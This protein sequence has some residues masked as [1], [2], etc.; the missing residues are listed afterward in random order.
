[1]AELL[2]DA[3]IFGTGEPQSGLLSDADI[4]GVGAEPTSTPP[5]SGIGR[6]E[7]AGSQFV[8][9]AADV[10]ASVPKS[11]S[12]IESARAEAV[13]DA[14]DKIDAGAFSGPDDPRLWADRAYANPDYQGDLKSYFSASDEGKQQLR[15][16]YGAIFDNPQEQPLYKK[17]EEISERTAERFPVNPE[18]ASEFWAGTVPQGLGS[19]TGFLATGAAGR[20]AGVSA[21]ATAAGAGA[22]VG[23][24]GQFEEA[25][26]DGA[27]LEEAF[28]AGKLSAFVG[29]S[30][31]VPITGL[32]NRLDK[33]TGGGVKKALADAAKQ[34]TE[35]AVQEAF[36]TI[37]SNLIASDLVGYDPERNAF[38]G[39]GE[40][41]GAGF[42][43]GA[44]MQG[45]AAMVMPGRYRKA[46]DEGAQEQPA[47]DKP[48]APLTDADRASPLP[49]DLISEGKGLMDELLS[50]QD[51]GI[52]EGA[53]N[54]D[55]ILGTEQPQPA[56]AQPEAMTGEDQAPAQRVRQTETE[57]GLLSDE[58]V[59]GEAETAQKGMTVRFPAVEGDGSPQ[60]PVQV[61]NGNDADVA[62][63]RVAEPTEAQKEAGNYRKGH[64]KVSG[65][66]VSIENPKGSTRS[67]T[68]ADGN[69]WSVE[70]PAHYG[71]VK[72]TEGADGDHVDVYIGD[73]PESDTVYVVDQINADEGTF[74]EHKGLV[75]FQSAEAAIAA[76]DAAFNDGRGPDRRGAVTPMSVEAFRDWLKGG[77]TKKPI[78]WKRQA[79][80]A[81][82]PESTPSTFEESE[83]PASEGS[84]ITP[85][86]EPQRYVAALKRYATTTKKPLNRERIAKDL[87]IEPGQADRV[88]ASLV[89]QADAPITVS[90]DGTV[91]RRAQRKGPVDAITYLADR[92]G[93]N[94][95]EGHDLKKGRNLQRFV[96]QA[97]P[98]IR[99][100][101]MSIDEAGETLW[102]AGYFGPTDTTQR[103]TEAEVLD[104]IEQAH[105]GRGFTPEDQDQVDAAQRAR[106][107]EERTGNAENEIRDIAKDMGEIFG[108][109][110]VS[111][112]KEMAISQNMDAEAAVEVY[113]ERQAI[114]DAEE[115]GEAVPNEDDA[116]DIPFE[117][118]TPESGGQAG[119]RRVERETQPGTS[120]ESGD[121]G[122]QVAETGSQE[123]SQERVTTETV[124][125]VDGPREQSVIPGAEQSAHQAAQSRE[126]EGRGRI[127]PKV[128]QKDADEGLFAPE[129]TQGE[130]FA[131]R[132][133]HAIAFTR[134]LDRL[135]AGEMERG[136]V[137]SLGPTPPALQLAGLPGLPLV[138][139]Q[140]EARKTLDG[141]HKGLIDEGT[142]RR[143][144][145]LL[146]DPVLVSKQENNRY[147]A[148]IQDA[149]GG[150]VLVVIQPRGVIKNRPSNLV[151]TTH[152][153][154]RADSILEDIAN[155]RVTYRHKERSLRWFDQAQRQNAGEGAHRG[156]D[157]NIATDADLVNDER[158]R[159]RESTPSE[160]I[161][162]TI[163]DDLKARMKQRGIDDKVSLRIVDSLATVLPDGTQRT[164]DASYQPGR[165]LIT[166]ALDAK[167]GK[168]A[169]DHEAVH[170]LR[171]LG[172]F[173]DAEWRVLENAARND[174]KRM[175][176]IRK[177]YEPAGLTESQLEEEAIA[178]M[179]AD[180]AKGEKKTK[181][182]IRTAFERIKAFLESLGNALEGNGYRTA[183]D[184]FGDVE[185]GNIGTRPA[186]GQSGNMDTKYAAAWHGT[187][188]DFDVFKTDHIGTGEGA[189]AYGWG[190]YFAGK[191]E[192]AEHYQ[193]SLTQDAELDSFIES[194]A[195]RV[196]S[197]PDHGGAIGVAK[198]KD[199]SVLV[200]DDVGEGEAYGPGYTDEN[201]PGGPSASNTHESRRALNEYEKLKNQRGRLYKVDL[202]PQEDEYLLWDKPLKDQPQSEILL[203]LADEYGVASTA[204]GG[205][206]Y[207]SVQRKEG[208]GRAASMAIARSGI[209]GIKYLDGSSRNDGEGTY[210][211]VIFDDS[212]VSVTEKYSL[213]PEAADSQ[214]NRNTV[215]Q[216]FIARGQPLDRALRIPFD[217]FGGVDEKGEWQPGLKLYEKAEKTLTESR[218]RDDGVFGWLNGSLTAARTGL[219]DRYGLNEDYVRRERKL[220]LDKREIASKGAEILSFLQSENIGA[221][222]AKVL[223]AVLTG[224]EIGDAEWQN[225]AA[226]IRQAIDELGQEAVQLGLVSPESYERNHGTYLHRVYLKHEGDQPALAR[227]FTNFM[228]NKRKK[229]QGDAFKGRGIFLDVGIDRAMQDVTEFAEG[230]RGRPQKGE[231]FIILDKFAEEGG[232]VPAEND[233]A[234]PAKIEK[235][236]FWPADKAVPERYAKEGYQNR[237]EWEVRRTLGDKI[238]LWRDFTKAERAQMGEILDARYT[239]GKTFTLM[240]NDLATGR[241]YRDIAQN[242]E[243]A[244]TATPNG[245]WV[246]AGDFKRMW[247][248]ESVEWVRVPDVSIPNTGNKK[249][250]GAL[251]GK[252]VRAEI[253]RDLNEADIMMRPNLWTKLLTQW[254]LNKTARSPVVHMNNVMSN[255]VF[256]DLAD[257]RV[258][259]L[260]KGLRSYI[261]EDAEFQDA[262]DHGAFGSDIIS[263]EIRRNVLQPIL[264]DLQSEVAGGNPVTQKFGMLGK[265]A[266]AIWEKGKAF[267]RGMVE[268]YRM[269][270][271]VFRMAM[272]HRRRALGDSTENAADEARAQFL[273]YDI[274]APW[275]NTARR[276]ALPFIAYTY[277]AV[278]V[279]AKSVATRPWKMA[280]YFAMAY[281]ANALAYMIAPGD[282]DDE[283]NSMREQEKGN[284]WIGTPRMMRMPYRDEHGNPVFLDIRRWI[285]AGDVFDMGQGHGAFP[286]PAPIQFGGPLMLGAEL[287]LNK[288]AFTGDEI[289]NNLTDSAS[290]KAKKLSDWAWKS[291]MPSAAWVP[292]SWY[293]EK[294]GLAAKGAT[295]SQGRPYPLPEAVASSFGI[296]LKPQDVEE[297]FQWRMY[298][299]TKARRALKAE[300]RRMQRLYERGI[301]SDEYF[302]ESMRAIDEKHERINAEEDAIMPK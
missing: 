83:Q 165:K 14:F 232:L 229:I 77:D 92:G 12:L 201:Y 179:F 189:Q 178:D 106:E 162:D 11:I 209:P 22:A 146:A 41:S 87:K 23:G 80:P 204:D 219:L 274:R 95:N 65:L 203:K 103:P 197:H 212:H 43:T 140:T 157:E 82:L 202:A 297:N 15:Q 59:F 104:F 19:A 181:G 29:T 218:F 300:E 114:K 154:A 281:A 13:V 118:A 246:E 190:L 168:W 256:M 101:G 161:I 90:K 292:G 73:N 299:F 111:T 57:T 9:G 210:N 144:P 125:T 131:F 266:E 259:D 166:V 273:D 38:T 98:F 123:G 51:A 47:P 49:D 86:F 152:P 222:E 61:Q 81:I 44:L 108:Q 76:Y 267:D 217:W 169:L 20:V 128:E 271:E 262:R 149:S 119:N 298:E 257:V 62:A 8:R 117:R 291:W 133:R 75:G 52:P 5:E 60:A 177:R 211:Y 242:N 2:S 50:D 58:D 88:I 244:R 289:T 121:V 37:S 7:T 265:I 249:R 42:T 186:T 225:L 45:I 295:D 285:P 241:F 122:T 239:I 272:Y 129:D 247:Q 66:D 64:V 67:G 236:V 182:F 282:E 150:D 36:Q 99:K 251:S 10:A 55:T 243:W 180:W 176:E 235:R 206:L 127:R 30:E 70:M 240:A 96:P 130:M 275:V 151:V 78:A 260:V 141:K 174:R 264:D 115:I 250:W 26:R 153:K 270:D 142:L 205:T 126:A 35:E 116:A 302:E 107:E 213:R 48:R 1:M 158:F 226:P 255:M 248:D 24:A 155:G 293:W 171:D 102:N 294:I 40:A 238:T 237:G 193:K 105:S 156:F 261:S 268:L 170:A 215:S 139:R 277:R 278:P 253:W 32:L 21:A 63:E 143:L 120:S 276:T 188:H 214:E 199:G 224:E 39:T 252:Y 33:V 124:V 97:G 132:P 223:Q 183:A 25:L 136:E 194:R 245:N 71:Y 34:G 196:Y 72:R 112:I 263:Q 216:G 159:M 113:I 3:D 198:F 93:I 69:A 279:I 175:E 269:E 134:A 147:A 287:A 74:D 233:A 4:F 85:D 231:A 163:G 6:L 84:G 228:A 109:S 288:S 167:D 56:P 286:I 301:M 207:H 53:V 254:K 100:N 110:E 187:P 195:S 280:K 221:D 145:D 17:G 89:S 283:R 91:R 164:A 192:V 208:S 191:R 68:D 27:S 284:T 230:K 290:D 185:A 138:Y 172:L 54:A 79:D 296:K 160:D 31:A 94:D 16:K 234:T 220:D 28:D 184:V 135:K 148:L 173:K 18:Y 46:P 227:W 200:V 258:Q 137:L